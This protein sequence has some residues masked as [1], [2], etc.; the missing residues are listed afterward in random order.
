V[1][2][3]GQGMPL[4]LV[5]TNRY[6]AYNTT[7]LMKSIGLAAWSGIEGPESARAKALSTRTTTSITNAAAEYRAIVAAG[8]RQGLQVNGLTVPKPR[9]ISHIA[10]RFPMY[11][12][13]HWLALK[14]SECTTPCGDCAVAPPKQASGLR[15]LH[16]MEVAA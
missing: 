12:V 16:Q 13:L 9:C 14:L 4:A 15:H 1:I 2:G 3:A 11:P 6:C 5:M 8:W 10:Q 7:G